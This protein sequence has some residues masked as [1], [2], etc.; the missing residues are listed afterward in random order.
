[1]Y[2]RLSMYILSHDIDPQTFGLRTFTLNS[3]NQAM[4]DCRLT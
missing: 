1:M 3:Q 4:S 2:Q